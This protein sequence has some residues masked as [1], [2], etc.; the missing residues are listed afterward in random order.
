MRAAAAIANERHRGT[1]NPFHLLAGILS[2]GSEPG[3]RL[4]EKVGANE[5]KIREHLKHE[6]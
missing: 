3:A 1:V 5:A 2:Q 4:L 6:L